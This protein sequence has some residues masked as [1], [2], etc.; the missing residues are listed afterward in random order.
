[1]QLKKSFFNK[2]IFWKNIKSYWPVW[3]ILTL[4]A[5]IGL[6]IASLMNFYMNSSSVPQNLWYAKQFYEITVGSVPAIVSML[7]AVIC[8]ACV[9]SYLSS[10]RS[11]SFFHSL[12]V[13]REGL[14]ISA[15]LS[16]FAFMAVPTIVAV[17]L[18]ALVIGC[19]GVNIIGPAFIGMGISLLIEF[20]FYNFAVLCM[21]ISGNA[22]GGFIF[23]GIMNGVFVFMTFVGDELAQFFYF[24]HPYSILDQELTSWLC[25]VF[26]LSMIR[27][28]YVYDIPK[29]INFFESKAIRIEFRDM[30][31]L[32]YYVIIA[33]VF[34]A[35]SFIEYRKK[36]TESVGEV[37]TVKWVKPLFKL[38]FTTCFMLLFTML[39]Y[40]IFFSG[41]IN[42]EW[43]VVASAVVF[44]FLGYIFAEMINRKSFKIFK[45][46][47]PTFLIYVV[48]SSLVVMI[49]KF[50]LTGFE[51]RMPKSSEEVKSV[52]LNLDGMMEIED[53]AIIDEVIALHAA[54]VDNKDYIVDETKRIYELEAEYYANEDRIY[55]SYEYDGVSLQVNC[56]EYVGA[57]FMMATIEYSLA[58][59]KTLTR[60]YDIPV[61]AD[62]NDPE[63]VKALE[64][65]YNKPECVKS[66]IFNEFDPELFEIKYADILVHDEEGSDK[67]IMYTDHDAEELLKA[68]EKDIAAGNFKTNLYNIYQESDSFYTETMS[69]CFKA[70]KVQYDNYKLGRYGSVSSV[71]GTYEYSQYYGGYD[72]DS[73]ELYAYVRFSKDCVNTINFLKT[74]GAFE[75]GYNIYTE[76]AYNEMMRKRYAIT[77]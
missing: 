76:K 47:K 2:T 73:Y 1:M 65:I 46:L 69:L 57:R 13:S 68:I 62:G 35:V 6:P 38:G 25:P 27:A 70:T 7:F 74:H 19:R 77:K 52:F 43:Q 72:D 59:G 39:F 30:K 32:L 49:M 3:A 56:D 63:F 10:H 23:Y 53:P 58:N 9:F 71:P 36:E 67:D 31:Y 17:L 20:F 55:S 75:N 37:I 8:A 28:G 26:G 54:I 34:L 12:P 33:V 51:K 45:T 48:L 44:S 22:I 18:D 64:R 11:A 61:R 66:R 40:S 21:I 16:G 50:D 41:N 4:I 24:G 5:F 15:Y 60:R 42:A 29:D 14:F